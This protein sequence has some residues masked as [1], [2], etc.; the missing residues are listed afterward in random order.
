MQDG[1]VHRAEDD[2]EVADWGYVMAIPGTATT[3]PFSRI[4]KY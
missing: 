3:C 2:A 1:G 4:V